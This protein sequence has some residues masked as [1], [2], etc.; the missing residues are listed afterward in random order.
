[1]KDRRRIKKVKVR[2]E[3]CDYKTNWPIDAIVQIE[4]IPI[5]CDDPECVEPV[6]VIHKA[7]RIGTKPGYERAQPKTN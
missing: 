1:M 3:F 5:A 6:G 7:T 2:C 4:H